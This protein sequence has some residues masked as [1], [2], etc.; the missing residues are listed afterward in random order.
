MTKLEDLMTAD[1]EYDVQSSAELVD[2]ALAAV[3]V[4]RARSLFALTR[5]I[6][7]EGM[8]EFVD[9]ARSDINRQPLMFGAL[10]V[11]QA[12]IVS[13]LLNAEGEVVAEARS[14]W[15]ELSF[16]ERHELR[17]QFDSIRSSLPLHEQEQ[18]DLE[19]AVRN[20]EAQFGQAD[21]KARP[22]AIEHGVIVSEESPGAR[23]AIFAPDGSFLTTTVETMWDDEQEFAAGSRSGCT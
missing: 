12:A 3:A 15:F 18:V 2:G 16:V 14:L 7:P 6:T 20:A 5:R 1:S 8:A 23:A 22:A 17:E 13:L 11:G 21:W 19:R 9:L 4:V 10:P